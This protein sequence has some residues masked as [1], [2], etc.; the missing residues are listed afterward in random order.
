MFTSVSSRISVVV[1]IRPRIY[2]CGHFLSSIQKSSNLSFV[3]FVGKQQRVERYL[4]SGSP[5]LTHLI[6][7]GRRNSR[8]LRKILR[9]N[10]WLV[11]FRLEHRETLRLWPVQ[12]KPC[13]TLCDEFLL[14][15]NCAHALPIEGTKPALVW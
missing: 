8:K 4:N 12:R 14:E 5:D 7:P 6:C 11:S 3:G 2:F 9:L 15:C 1:F 13:V 10:T